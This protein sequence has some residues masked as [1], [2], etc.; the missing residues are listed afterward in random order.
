[1]SNITISNIL[2]RKGRTIISVLAVGIGVMMLLVLVGMTQGTL[3]EVAERMQNVDADML[4]HARSW[5]P[6]LDVGT[7]PLDARF[8]GKLLEIDG[9]EDV[10]PVIVGRII[11]DNQGQNFFGI[12]PGDFDRVASF[13]KVIAGRDLKGGYELLIDKRLADAGGYKVGQKIERFGKEFR[14][15]GI[16]ETGVPVR[17]FMPI[18]TVREEFARQN[19]VSY[20]FIKCDSPENIGTVASRIESKY[21]SLKCMPLGNYYQALAGSFRGL[22]QF[23]AG[24]TSVSAL[25]SFLVILLAMYTTVLERTREIG[26]LKSLGA[27][28][29]FIMRDIMAESVIICSSGVVVGIVF[30]VGVKYAL[31]EA[32]PLLTVKLTFFWILIGIILGVVGG[33]LGAVYPA[34]I[35][36]AKDPV[37]ALRYE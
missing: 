16:C 37:E 31:Q 32:L 21:R 12:D 36:S 9:V 28:R 13:R 2:H 5:N 1:M 18:E 14:V 15:V 19:A 7:A 27:S 6:V 11:L 25:I 35:A 22:H 8:E 29:F 24:V 23:I 34:C 17:V 20:F 10:T 26:I 33:M 4:V 3:H 30:A